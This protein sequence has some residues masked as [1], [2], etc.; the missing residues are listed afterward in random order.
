MLTD[1]EVLKL[2]KYA[3]TIKNSKIHIGIN[4][5]FDKL[6]ISFADSVSLDI[7]KESLENKSYKEIKKILKSYKTL[8][9]D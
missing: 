5:E 6:T 3:K 7:V 1:E 9:E 8:S 2:I 4:I